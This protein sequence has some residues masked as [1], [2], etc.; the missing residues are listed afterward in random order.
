LFATLLVVLDQRSYSQQLE[1]LRNEASASCSP[2]YKY[3]T[4]VQ[5]TLRQ[6]RLNEVD[7]KGKVHPMTGHEGQE[8]E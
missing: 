3:R 1:S 8:G 2:A 5:G 4:D 6:E 7:G